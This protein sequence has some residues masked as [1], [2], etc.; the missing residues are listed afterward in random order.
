MTALGVYLY[1]R[2]YI[3]NLKIRSITY[4]LRA[5]HE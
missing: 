1:N 2:Q 5:Y 3:A 4:Y